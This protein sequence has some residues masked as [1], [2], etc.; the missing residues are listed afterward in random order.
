MQLILEQKVRLMRE[1]LAE[2]E[3]GMAD[4]PPLETTFLPPKAV[5]CL[6]HGLKTVKAPIRQIPPRSY[7]R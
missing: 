1:V 7:S 4:G 3:Q 5:S 6:G 2:S